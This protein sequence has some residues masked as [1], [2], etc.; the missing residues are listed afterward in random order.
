MKKLAAVMLSVVVVSMFL[1][2]CTMIG[3]LLGGGD[4]GPTYG[5]SVSVVD[6]SEF[7]DRSELGYTYEH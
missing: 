7:G 4:K 3:S 5:G 6:T 2:G 1:S